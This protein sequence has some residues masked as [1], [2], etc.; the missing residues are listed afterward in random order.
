MSVTSEAF[1]PRSEM[2]MFEENEQRYIYPKP[3]TLQQARHMLIEDGN[4]AGSEGFNA[5]MR[6]ILQHYEFV[7]TPT[8]TY[9]ITRRSFMPPEGMQ[10]RQ[11]FSLKKEKGQVHPLWPHA[12]G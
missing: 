10:K 7:T 12:T 2:P 9:S 3:T 4:E 5:A 6:G 11:S 8:S 1:D